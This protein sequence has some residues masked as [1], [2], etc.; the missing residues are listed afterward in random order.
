MASA[1]THV[2]TDRGDRDTT[3]THAFNLK[4]D[5]LKL[6]NKNI[7]PVMVVLAE[8]AIF[9]AS[10][11]LL[12]RVRSGVWRNSLLWGDPCVVQAMQ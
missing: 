11:S 6:R 4:I 10:H 3:H 12:P 8:P 7:Q 5:I 2:Y 9:F 1:G